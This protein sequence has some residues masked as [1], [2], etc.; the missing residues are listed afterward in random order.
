MLVLVLV[1]LV[2]LLLLLVTATQN[3]EQISGI[4]PTRTKLAS[5][6]S[7]VRAGYNDFSPPIVVHGIWRL[8]WPPWGFAYP[9][10][11]AW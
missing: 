10:A 8:D 6:P 5:Q 3:T 1:L 9:L 4:L 2:L 7:I 11:E